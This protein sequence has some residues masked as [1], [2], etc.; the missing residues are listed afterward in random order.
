VADAVR[1]HAGLAAAGPGEDEEG[2]FDV[3][4]GLALLRVEGGK[5]V[6]GE[7]GEADF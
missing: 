1:D 3:S 2:S 7:S 5:E 6:H 4:G